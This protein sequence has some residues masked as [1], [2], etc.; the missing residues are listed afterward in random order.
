VPIRPAVE[1]A[2]FYVDRRHRG[3]GLSREL[4]IHSRH[5]AWEFAAA[6]IW[7]CAWERNPRALAFYRKNGFVDV[8]VMSIRVPPTLFHDIVFASEIRV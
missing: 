6:A 1:I 2:R 4:L 7:L 5:A 8:G 3:T